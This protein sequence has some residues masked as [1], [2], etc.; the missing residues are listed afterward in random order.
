MSWYEYNRWKENIRVHSKTNTPQS[1]VS[2][3]FK[4]VLSKT[5]DEHNE[6]G[7]AFIVSKMDLFI[8]GCIRY[9]SLNS[10]ASIVPY[11]QVIDIL[12]IL[13]DNDYLDEFHSKITTCCP[14]WYIKGI[15]DNHIEHPDDIYFRF[16]P[17]NVTSDILEDFGDKLSFIHDSNLLQSD[18]D[19]KNMFVFLFNKFIMS[20]VNYHQ[21]TENFCK[22]PRS[23]LI[24]IDK[25]MLIDF[26]HVLMDMLDTDDIHHVLHTFPYSS[27]FYEC[28][29]PIMDVFTLCP[30]YWINNPPSINGIVHNPLITRYDFIEFCHNCYISTD[31]DYCAISYLN[32]KLMFDIIQTDSLYISPLSESACSSLSRSAVNIEDVVNSVNI[33]WDWEELSRNPLIATPEN[34]SSYPKLPWIW[35][36]WGITSSPSLTPD[37]IYANIDKL[38]KDGDVPGSLSSNPCVTPQIIEDLPQINWDYTYSGLS[39]NPNITLPFFVKNIDKDWN[40]FTVLENLQFCE[41][42]AAKAIQGWWKIISVMRKAKKLSHDVIEWYYHPDCYPAMKNRANRFYDQMTV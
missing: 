17:Y 5:I 9:L 40:L 16:T 22:I 2:T 13:D 33:V 30:E 15:I 14:Y 31:I 8:K 19:S 32:P 11:K 18:V 42:T 24:Y 7:E 27:I 28:A 39:N 1:I 10:N 12:K 41:E 4:Y 26:I 23:S 6:Q 35:G 21:M 34:I 37:F 29:I 3:I 25:T 38:Y 36:K 20:E